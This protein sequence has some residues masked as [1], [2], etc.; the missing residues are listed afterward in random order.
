MTVSA[1]SL[2]P[3]THP[4]KEAPIGVVRRRQ[5]RVPL[6]GDETPLLAPPGCV[7]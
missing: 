1:S 7:S 5:V 3:A 6:R 4:R 2:H